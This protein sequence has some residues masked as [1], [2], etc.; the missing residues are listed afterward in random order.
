[1]KFYFCE[2]CGKRITDQQVEEG[3][4]R[5]KKLKGVYC[6][7]CAVGVMTIEFNAITDVQLRDSSPPRGQ[8]VQT[9]PVGAKGSGINLA[10]ATRGS[11]RSQTASINKPHAATPPNNPSPAVYAAAGAVVLIAVVI[12]AVM[13]TRKTG[14]TATPPA[15]AVTKSGESNARPLVPATASSIQTPTP[16]ATPKEVDLSQAVEQPKVEPAP[17]ARNSDPETQAKAEYEKL[18]KFEGLANDDPAARVAALEGFL[19]T[20]TNSAVGDQA[21]AFIDTLKKPAPIQTPPPEP[22]PVTA[23][24]TEAKPA[25][26][27]EEDEGQKHFVN[28]MKEV[29]PQLRQNQ[30]AAAAKL[31]D[32]KL[33]DPALADASENL[34]NVKA[35]LA[36]V[37]SLRQL[38]INALRAKNG[39]SLSLKLKTGPVTGTVKDD[40]AHSDLTL[41]LRDGPEITVTA[42]QLDAADVDAAVPLETEG[43]KAADLRRRG[44][45]F[46]VTGDFE[47]ANNYFAKAK[48]AGLSNARPSYVNQ[49]ALFVG[50]ES[51]APPTPAVKKP[52]VSRPHSAS[53][54]ILSTLNI[55][56]DDIVVH[57]QFAY[58]A[59]STENKILVVDIS[60]PK[61]MTV[62]DPG[63]ATSAPEPHRL[64][65]QGKF[66]YVVEGGASAQLEIFDVAKPPGLTSVGHVALSSGSPLAL[67]VSGTYAYVLQNSGAEIGVYDVSKSNSPT[68]KGSAHIEHNTTDLQVQ[69]RYVYT[70]GQ[71]GN[72]GYFAIYDVS[73][74]AAPTLVGS[75]GGWQYP[76]CLLVQDGYGYWPAG[77]NK[78]ITVNVNNPSR[79]TLA[80]GH[81]PGFMSPRAIAAQ[82]HLLLAVDNNKTDQ[83][84]VY[85]STTPAAPKYLRKFDLGAIGVRNMAVENGY[86]YVVT[87]K[88][89]ACV[90]LSSNPMAGAGK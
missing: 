27:V 23:T 41:A 52:V 42:E 83:L 72:A 12:F 86:L 8:P 63:A 5:D 44:L 77:N 62:V 50:T 34:K 51:A 74:A 84:Q 30:L 36:E 61:N 32:E 25:P 22:A 81:G 75:T 14:S 40:A 60:D 67:E 73:N 6:Q 85:D 76:H 68:R 43:G 13:G 26:K 58:C 53:M 11:A 9:P 59:S 71:L 69:G 79:P 28:V 80:G 20:H 54:T 55:A 65:L 2:T 33:R 21:R 89:L 18:I 47:R 90:D 39:T 66:L 10:A 70:S 24:A 29:V 57:E 16:A 82:G 64:R 87:G 35:D 19:A 37:R 38:A 45:L 31:I 15:V 7:E 56:A 49:I 78:L 17:V 4:A 3:S 88:A 46:V 48:D 1:M